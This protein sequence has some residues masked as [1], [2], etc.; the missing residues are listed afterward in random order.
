MKSLI[1]V[2][3]LKV[4]PPIL[5]AFFGA[6]AWLTAK[7]LSAYNFSIKGAFW[8]SLSLASIGFIFAAFGIIEFFKAKTTVNPHNPENTSILVQSGIY[9]V[10]RNPMYVGL[11]L[12][13]VA[14]QFYIFNFLSLICLPLFLVCITFFQ[15]V[16]EEKVL[17]EK[18]GAEFRE[19]MTQV[20]RWI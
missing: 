20:R 13:L 3:E 10:T 16:P 2:L 15:I 18:F 6:I 4:P 17:Q 7:Y 19:Y 1:Q 12:L 11:F 5:M 14:W 8:I 9:K